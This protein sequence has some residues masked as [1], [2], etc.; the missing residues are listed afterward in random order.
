MTP[1]KIEGPLE[2]LSEVNGQSRRRNIRE[3]IAV[4]VSSHY[5]TFF[6]VE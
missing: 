3:A 4:S 6:S 1:E 2:V 5:T